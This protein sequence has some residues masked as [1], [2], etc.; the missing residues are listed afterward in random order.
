VK[1]PQRN[2][3]NK[4]EVEAWAREQ[5]AGGPAVLKALVPDPHPDAGK[6][7]TWKHIQEGLFAEKVVLLFS[8]PPGL[9]VTDT[10]TGERKFVPSASRVGLVLGRTK[11]DEFIDSIEEERALRSFVEQ[12]ND[13]FNKKRQQE[14]EREMRSW[15]L[16]WYHHGRRICRFVQEHPSISTERVWQELV[17]WGQG[18]QGYGRQTH[19]DVTYFFLWLGE[20]DGKHPVFNLS[21]TRIQ[22]ILWADR[23]KAGRDRLLRAI[24]GGPF[25]GLSDDEFAWVVGKRTSNWP[26]GPAEQE[27]MKSFGLRI[28]KG[29]QLSHDE[30]KRFEDIL[31]LVRQ[32]PRGNENPAP[33]SSSDGLT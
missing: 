8:N 12:E 21:T 5:L 19:Q 9:I 2:W 28:R 27:E 25:R 10:E 32:H 20:V 23:T 29:L 16:E 3:K 7:A 30:Q 17:K 4:A 6:P 13:L 1:V 11:P 33:Q 24:V 31:R 14:A 18:Q 15:T 22:H 26:L